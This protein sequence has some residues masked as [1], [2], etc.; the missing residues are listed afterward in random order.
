MADDARELAG[1][2][3]LQLLVVLPPAPLFVVADGARIDQVLTNLVVNSV[4]YTDA[5]EV[6]ARRWIRWDA[7]P[8]PAFRRRR[9]RTRHSRGRSAT[10]LEPDKFVTTP[11][12]RGEGSGIGLAIV[13]TLVDHL[14][15]TL[16]VTS[17][18]GKGTTFVVDI[19]VLPSPRQRGL[20]RHG[21][22]RPGPGPR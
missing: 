3:G 20:C 8:A 10:L 21:H 16:G 13:R 17:T 4:R 5:G 14:G 22:P 2:K 11:A 7:P 18:L 9:H 6:R 1:A 19:P 12:R 15:G